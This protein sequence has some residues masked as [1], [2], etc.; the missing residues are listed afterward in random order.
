MVSAKSVYLTIMSM[1]LVVTASCSLEKTV[2]AIPANA[3]PISFM[4]ADGVTLSGHIFGSGDGGVILSHMWR[5]DESR[6]FDFASD[7]S[8]KGY[9]V[10]T[11][12]FRGYG[13]SKEK[14]DVALIDRDLEAAVKT[15]KE[16]RNIEKLYLI[17]S[18]MGGTA[19]IK[20]AAHESVSALVVLSAPVEI[21]KLDSKNDVALVKAP[22]LF[23]YSEND[24]IA[25]ESAKYFLDNGKEPIFS[26]ALVGSEHGTDILYGE[27]GPRIKDMIVR[28]I[29][30]NGVSRAENR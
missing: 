3:E 27:N 24:V 21:S 25:N 20:V 7:L 10:L 9:S 11:Y 14:R 13:D 30:R 23:I 6:W 29:D 15:L 16:H 17:G 28:F 19:S 2:A 26:E 22:K 1:L 4:T 8:D 5:D 18:S 12:N